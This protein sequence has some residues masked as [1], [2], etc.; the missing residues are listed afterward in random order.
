MVYNTF[1][2]QNNPLTKII[3]TIGPTCDSPEK[4]EG[5]INAGVSVFRFNLKHN[6][7]EWHNERI[8]RIH[9]V[10]ERIGQP[11]AVLLDLQGPEIRI[12]SFVE[13]ELKVQT[14]EEITFA[15]SRQLGERTIVVDNLK[16]LQ[17]LR[18]GQR[19]L[20]DDGFLQFEVTHGR[21]DHV[22]AQVIKGGTVSSHKGMNIPEL[23]VE[24]PVLVE[25][26][27][28]HLDLAARQ[29]VDFVAL[30][31]VRRGADIEEL[32]SEMRRRK[33]KAAIIA[34]I[35]N[36]MALDNFDEILE[37]TD[38]VM[39][40]RGDLGIE[41]E[42][43]KLPFFQKEIIRKTR[44]AGKPVITA[45]Q[46][47]QSMV[48]QPIPTRAEVSDV[49]NA[50]FDY[51]DAIMLSA[52][53]AHGEYPLESVQMMRAI[54]KF[55]ENKRMPLPADENSLSQVEAMVV[56]AYKLYQ[57]LVHQKMNPIEA[58]VILTNSGTTARLLARMRPGIPVIAVT[59]HRSIRDQLLISHGI[60]PLS[61]SFP[62]GTIHSFRALFQLLV[63]QR[64][65]KPG[66]NVIVLHGKGWKDSGKTN[67]LSIET[68]SG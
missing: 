18:P 17:S 23:S 34:K 25:K 40:A 30:S 48:T 16:L 15:R 50:I 58:F 63:R 5:L 32:R 54:A 43:Y 49:A 19:V 14:G 7:Q 56:S 35:E 26:D 3:A 28:K 9:A 20:V 4:I 55:I 22:D 37:S 61:F 46:M 45:T 24:L 42:M 53:T 38:G 2:I 1:M 51:T 8:N 65:L 52:E 33:L 12:G 39:I 62:E 64:L 11:V 36:Q 6:T 57:V 27:L 21:K 31:F 68:V 60:I 10:S 67:A 29:E 44:E 13:G 47:L 66:D 41:V 59:P